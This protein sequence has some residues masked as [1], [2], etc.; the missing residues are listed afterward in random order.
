MHR[1]AP[2]QLPPHAS[3]AAPA[4]P[5]SCADLH[6]ATM[7]YEPSVN[8]SVAASTAGSELDFGGETEA[9]YT[10]PSL[11]DLVRCCV[12]LT[13]QQWRCKLPRP[14]LP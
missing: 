9:H 12:A 7:S 6:P 10:L 13:W 4:L 11:T 1:H 8:G 5:P 3:S 2:A 14:H